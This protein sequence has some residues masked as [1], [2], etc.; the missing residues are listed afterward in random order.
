MSSHC[1]FF[2][3]HI[4]CFMFSQSGS[5]EGDS[6]KKECIE[7]HFRLVLDDT[8]KEWG[9]SIQLKDWGYNFL[10]NYFRKPVLPKSTSE[11]Q[12]AVLDDET[13]ASRVT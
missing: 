7:H 12:T 11:S 6:K 13:W 2:H 8:W 4:F 3:S 9:R 5:L 1:Q 10:L